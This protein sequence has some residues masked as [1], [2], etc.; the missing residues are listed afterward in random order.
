MILIYFHPLY[1]W[2]MKKIY[3]LSAWVFIIWSFLF[4]S[5]VNG[6]DIA[7]AIHK[8][9][10][11]YLSLVLSYSLKKN[12][13][14]CR[15]MNMFMVIKLMVFSGIAKTS[16]VSFFFWDIWLYIVALMTIW[17]ML[18]LT[19]Y[20]FAWIPLWKKVMGFRK[21]SASSQTTTRATSA[22]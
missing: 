16:T 22:T 20:Q 6:I 3:E 19:V 9:C 7:W 8:I 10:W 15:H 12:G 5:M 21:I 17:V 18:F 2:W 4:I 1:G 13:W 11:L 14:K